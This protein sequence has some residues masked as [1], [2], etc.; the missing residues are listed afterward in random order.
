MTRLLLVYHAKSGLLNAALDSARKLLSV[1][2]CSLCSIT[3]GTFGEKKE[4]NSCRLG[5]GIP[6]EGLHLDELSPELEP[7]VSGNTPCVVAQTETGYQL[8]LGPGPLKR[9]NNSPK[10]LITAMAQ[11]AERQ[12]LQIPDMDEH[13][14]GDAETVLAG[15]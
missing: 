4:W 15:V 6:V 5:L 12:R 8:L 7:L 10:L 1:E 9:C 13:L 11:A 14:A 2:S 3:H